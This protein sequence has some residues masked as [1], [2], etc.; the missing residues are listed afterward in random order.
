MWALGDLFCVF[1]VFSI[2]DGDNFVIMGLMD[3]LFFGLCFLVLYYRAI[4]FVAE[5]W[6][7]VLFCVLKGGV[8]F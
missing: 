1:G 3:L 2:V 6:F 5:F 7:V 4:L 8:C